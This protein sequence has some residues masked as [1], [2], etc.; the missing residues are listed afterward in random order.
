MVVVDPLEFVHDGR[1]VDIVVIASLLTQ[2]LVLEVGHISN[3]CESSAGE[4]ERG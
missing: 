2:C 1:V 3:R 4:D